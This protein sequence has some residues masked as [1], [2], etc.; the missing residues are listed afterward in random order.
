MPCPVESASV[1]LFIC[2]IYCLFALLCYFTYILFFYTNVLV[3]FHQPA[4]G[5]Q[6]EN[7]QILFEFTQFSQDECLIG[8]CPC[9]EINKLQITK[10]IYEAILK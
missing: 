3:L 2:F 5:L 8:H 6:V 4:Q 1:F 9:L 7:S 10:R